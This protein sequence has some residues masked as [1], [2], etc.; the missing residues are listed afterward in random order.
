M[1]FITTYFYAPVNDEGWLDIRGVMAGS[2]N[3]I[4]FK[5]FQG[6]EQ[7]KPLIDDKIMLAGNTNEYDIKQFIRYLIENSNW[8]TYGFGEELSVEANNIDEALSK[9]YAKFQ[10][11]ELTTK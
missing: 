5:A 9:A 7:F 2:N 1:K 6:S 3:E 10:S 11:G 4:K 8:Q